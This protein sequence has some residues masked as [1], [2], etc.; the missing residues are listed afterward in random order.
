[1]KIKSY[2]KRIVGDI[3]KSYPEQIFNQ[4]LAFQGYGF[5]ECLDVNSLVQLKDGTFIKLKDVKIGDQIK[6]MD[7]NGNI[8]FVK[9]KN[10]FHNKKPLYKITTQSNHQLISSLD[11]KYKTKHGM[12]K[13]KE[14]I[15]NNL[16]IF[17][18]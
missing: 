17:S 7:N 16:E 15:D 1:M 5:N 18:I 6:S 2:S 3:D 11:H 8:I 12:V 4:L 13:L 9:I 10:I 14:I